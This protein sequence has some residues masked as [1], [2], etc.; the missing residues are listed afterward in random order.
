MKKL[1]LFLILG[2]S[3]EICVAGSIYGTVKDVNYNTPLNG[4]T[5]KL[6]LNSNLISSKTSDSNGN[7]LFSGLAQADY[8]IEF[9]HQNYLTSYNSIFVPD[10]LQV[11]LTHHMHPKIVTCSVQDILIDRGNGYVSVLDIPL[12]IEHGDTLDC[13]LIV[14]NTGNITVNIKDSIWSSEI[15]LTP[16]KIISNYVSVNPNENWTYQFQIILDYGFLNGTKDIKFA[17]FARD[18]NR[19]I[20]LTNYPQSTYRI[21]DIFQL[22][23]GYKKAIISMVDFNKAVYEP[24]ENVDIAIKIKNKG[25]VGAIYNV[26]TVISDV[27]QNSNDYDSFDFDYWQHGILLNVDEEVICDKISWVV[28]ENYNGKSCYVYISVTRNTDNGLIEYDKSE[29]LFY[30]ESI[31]EIINYTAE[32]YRPINGIPEV[33]PLAIDGSNLYGI[34]Y[35]NNDSEIQ[36][37]DGQNY[38]SGGYDE[39]NYMIITNNQG[40]PYYQQSDLFRKALF[41]TLAYELFQKV[42]PYWIENLNQVEKLY[43]EVNLIYETDQDYIQEQ[44]NYQEFTIRL[45]QCGKFLSGLGASSIS[46][47]L[48]A[49]KS[50]TELA[51]FKDATLT[52]IAPFVANEI[53]QNT[54]GNQKNT[55]LLKNIPENTPIPIVKGEEPTDFIILLAAFVFFTAAD[56]AFEYFEDQA[57][58]N[59]VNLK[60]HEALV[61]PPLSYAKQYFMLGSINTYNIGRQI[62]LKSSSFRRN[63]PTYSKIVDCLGWGI[64][65][66]FGVNSGDNSTAFFQYYI[67]GLTEYRSYLLGANT[68][69]P[70]AFNSTINK[71]DD[72][73]TDINQQQNRMNLLK[74]TIYFD[75]Y[76]LGLLGIE[77]INQIDDNTFHN[78]G[79]SMQVLLPDN[80]SN[81]ILDAEVVFYN[82][83]GAITNGTVTWAI[84]ET[85]L[86]GSMVH[87]GSGHYT[88]SIDISEIS[89]INSPKTYRFEVTAEKNGETVE[90]IRYFTILPNVNSKVVFVVPEKFN[91]NAEE[92]A[93]KNWLETQYEVFTI[94]TYDF[95]TSIPDPDENPVITILNINQT[96]HS[97]LLDADFHQKIKDYMTLGGN[98]FLLGNA[99]E[100]LDMTGITNNL[101]TAY[102][103]SHYYN[104]QY[105]TNV[106]HPITQEYTQ[107]FSFDIYSYGA[108]YGSRFVAADPTIGMVDLGSAYRNSSYYKD[109][110]EVPYGTGKAVFLGRARIAGEYD[111]LKSLMTRIID[112]LQNQGVSSVKADINTP[113]PGFQNQT[114]EIDVDVTAYGGVLP[115]ESVINTLTI[116]A[117]TTL[118]YVKVDGVTVANNLGVTLGTMNPGMTKQVTYGLHCATMGIKDFSTNVITNYIQIYSNDECKKLIHAPNTQMSG[119]LIIDDGTGNT[120]ITALKSWLTWMG[121]TYTASSALNIGNFGVP[122]GTKQVI[123]HNNQSAIHPDFYIGSF[124]SKIRTF[125]TEG[126]HVALFGN[127]MEFLDISEITNGLI[128]NFNDE[129]DRQYVTN[130]S[131]LITNQYTLNYYFDPT[132]SDPT[133]YGSSFTTN[134]SITKLGEGKDYSSAAQNNFGTISFGSG[135]VAFLGNVTFIDPTDDIISLVSRI[136]NYGQY[137]EP[138]N[139]SLSL[140]VFLEGTYNG[141]DMNTVLN[142]THLP[143]IQPYNSVPWNYSG[144]ESVVA[145]PNSDVVDWVMVEI[146]EATTAGLAT[147]STRQAQQAAFILKNG[148]IVGLDGLSNLSFTT[149]NTNNLYVIVWHRNHLG[150]ISSVPLMLNGGLSS[151]D[152][153]TGSDKVFGGINGLKELTLG[154]W[155][156]YSG[157]GD[158]N[159][160]I[161]MTDKTGIWS[162][163]AGK[164]GYLNADFNLDGQVDNRDKNE[165]WLPNLNKSSQ[166][167]E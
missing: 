29:S 161:N 98:L 61:L 139:F 86:T 21:Q 69:D 83:N 20:N 125:L 158:A 165:F 130:I 26:R 146:R 32:H 91:L 14:K 164:T 112:H 162:P 23:S 127:A 115:I 133:L 24:G 5:I 40:V 31:P 36:Y 144:T 120:E 3:I 74:G 41:T 131:H 2:L 163:N 129:I 73:F 17:V 49:G 50:L 18:P 22:E 47:P 149:I 6:Y 114:F 105:I 96:L 1:F 132:K 90:G 160:I 153:T 124:N 111:G 33:F 9:I 46:G 39:I 121:Y 142:P 81:D 11:N 166:V 63:K 56:I 123:L 108:I 13:R 92:L 151:Y 51:D 152:F 106:N 48:M 16:E 88:A 113:V 159:R 99:T 4:A 135:E 122:I 42:E 119:I 72:Y 43:N 100:L 157:N 55:N 8:D 155:G 85:D 101:F 25:K 70:G 80:I 140:K 37:F 67:M 110:G 12:E 10:T 52:F 35:Y 58:A 118:D 75:S 57:E 138:T 94:S 126:G 93:Y 38:W 104:S 62:L 141:N 78:N 89:N 45:A 156:M 54:V 97:S 64:D 77:K 143:L 68:I 145:I 95:K 87:Q 28:P 147:N 137:T 167:P 128:N 148:S 84:D 65:D 27:P 107:N 44:I 76:S 150:I 7:F 117:N 66:P 53:F 109:F 154:K 15:G 30:I 116:P 59:L 102:D 103:Y 82:Y 79:L 71:H 134:A 136:L 34:I 19:P 60:I